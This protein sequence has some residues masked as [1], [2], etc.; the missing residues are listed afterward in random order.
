[1]SSFRGKVIKMIKDAGN[2]FDDYSFSPKIRQIYCIGVLKK[3]FLLIC[4]ITV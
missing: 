4:Q 2:K 3:I 1:M